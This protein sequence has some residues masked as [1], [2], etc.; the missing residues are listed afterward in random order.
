[1]AFKCEKCG[2]EHE[3]LPTDIGYAR[4]GDFMRGAAARAQAA[5]PIHR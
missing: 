4:P 3:G 1:M 5:L 2:Q